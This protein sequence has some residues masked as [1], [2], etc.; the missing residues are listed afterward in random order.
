MLF[1]GGGWG[2]ISPLLFDEN[3]MP[4]HLSLF[5]IDL[6]HKE[7]ETHGYILKTMATETLV[8]KHQAI[9]IH[10]ADQISIR[11]DQLWTI[12]WHL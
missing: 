2:I 4:S 6:W 11:L 12:L 5:F 9:S 8:L 10:I 3:G 1:V 7:L